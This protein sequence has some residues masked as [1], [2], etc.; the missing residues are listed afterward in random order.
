MEVRP[1]SPGAPHARPVRDT[2][3]TSRSRARRAS[4]RH[5]IPHA[6]PP[7]NRP[8]HS[9][10]LP[11]TLST[12]HSNTHTPYTHTPT[13]CLRAETPSNA[14][15][16]ERSTRLKHVHPAAQIKQ[17]L[18]REAAAHQAQH[19]RSRHCAPPGCPASPGAKSP[20]ASAA[21][22]PE[23]VE[24]YAAKCHWKNQY[25]S[26]RTAASRGTIPGPMGRLRRSQLRE[27]PSPQL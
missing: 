12:S 10:A 16:V 15:D 1:R 19:C 8:T 23:S 13:T 27:G 5:T 2:R 4:T 3:A 20:A 6:S 22:T 9:T 25:L 18:T 7:T 21:E 17:R 11:P 26:G 24:Q 14:G